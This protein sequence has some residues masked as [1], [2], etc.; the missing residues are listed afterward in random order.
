M[1]TESEKVE[2]MVQAMISARNTN[3]RLHQE[4]EK[5]SEQVRVLREALELVAKEAIWEPVYCRDKAREALKA[6]EGK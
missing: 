6:T 5:L 3:K 2:S 4:N 1:S